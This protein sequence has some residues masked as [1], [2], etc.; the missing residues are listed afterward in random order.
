MKILLTD[1]ERMV[2]LGL[3]SMLDELYPGQHVYREARDGREMLRAA[4]E[5]R[6]D[7]A[8]VDIRMPLLGG[9]EALEQCRQLCP[10]TQYLILSGY[11]DFEYART[12]IRLGAVEYLLKPVSLETLGAA[13]GKAMDLVQTRIR[14]DNARFAHLITH[15]YNNSTL[16]REHWGELSGEDRELRIALV[17]LDHREVAERTHRY[18]E[19]ADALRGCLEARLDGSFLYALF[20]TAG[21]AL[22]LVTAGDAPGIAPLLKKTGADQWAPVTTLDCREVSPASFYAICQELHR[23]LATR[24]LWGCG[25]VSAWDPSVRARVEALSPLATQLNAL[26]EAFLAHRE[27]E[28][29]NILNQIYRDGGM[30]ALFRQGEAS[31]LERYFQAAL[32]LEVET[33]SFRDFVHSLITGADKMYGSGPP[34]EQPDVITYVTGYIQENYM[35]DIEIVAIA[36]EIGISPNY[37]SRIFHERVGSKFISYLTEVRIT[38]A[39]RLFTQNPNRTVKEVA[40][41]VGYISVRHFTKTFTRLTGCLPSAYGH[42][43]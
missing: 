30:E 7:I 35:R 20:Y 19:L 25:R 33:G 4:A 13:M 23:G 27:I 18:G 21:S 12:G 16:G 10:G 42:K 29:K 36:K 5:F 9:L 8:F 39:K 3:I 15:A 2:R 32:G 41:M 14:Q 24:N 17:V 37:L 28:Y 1:D 31:S 43:K 6:P 22:C 11:S 26:T 38:N 40:G 34:K